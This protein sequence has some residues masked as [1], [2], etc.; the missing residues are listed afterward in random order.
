MST[1]PIEPASIESATS[2]GT[3]A[4]RPH[5]TTLTFSPGAAGPSVGLD[6]CTTYVPR[7]PEKVIVA[8]SRSITDV[9]LVRAEMNK[10]WRDWGPYSIVSGQARGVDRIAARIARDAGIE[11]HEMPADW[12]THGRS[13][14]YIRNAGMAKAAT[15]ALIIYD[16]LSKG[17]SH[18]IRIAAAEGIRLRVVAPDGWWEMLLATAPRTWDPASLGSVEW[19]MLPAGRSTR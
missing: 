13:A 18:M 7:T 9:A 16:G 1:D 5:I 6:I 11:V 4:D 12:D 2:S 14:G 3:S 8:G 19:A 15:G 10:L 17:S